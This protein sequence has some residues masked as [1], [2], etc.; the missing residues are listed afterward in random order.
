VK[1]YDE[2][3]EG[4]KELKKR[5]FIKTHRFD[6][7][8]IGK[9]L[10]DELGIEENNFEGP[11]GIET[12]LKSARKTATSML[13]LFTKAPQPRGINS[14]LRKYYG[15]RH[16]KY[17]VNILQTNV[18][19]IDY[20]TI[21][22]EKGFKILIEKDRIVLDPFKKI[23]EVTIP[24]WT[25]DLIIDKVKE[26][27]GDSL[28]YVKADSHGTGANEEFHYNQAWLLRGFSPD[29]FFKQLQDGN[30]IINI[31][32]GVHDSGP[33]RGKPHDYGT[34]FRINPSKID[35]CF[36]TRKQIV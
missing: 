21:K 4:I 1:T 23:P 35:L 13:S 27:Y 32:L 10:E 29:V 30:L 16:E 9:T 28:L 17:P 33:K 2:L 18:N 34:G 5:G 6:D 20:N 8:G 36:K 24:Y 3:L 15:Y 14:K 31:R 11:D 25:R 12:E 26:K 7:T 22:T 19:T